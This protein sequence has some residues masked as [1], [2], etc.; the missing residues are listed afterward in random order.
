[1]SSVALVGAVEVILGASLTP[2][3][4]T[5]KVSVAAVAPFS[6]PS[7]TDNVTLPELV[8]PSVGVQVTTPLLE[9]CIPNGALL[10]VQMRSVPL[11]LSSE[12]VTCASY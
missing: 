12:S 6:P 4:L 3:T 10:S 2:T 11:L 7:A 8:M 9:T 1:M 5:I